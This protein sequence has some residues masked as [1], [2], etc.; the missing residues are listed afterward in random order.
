MKKYIFLFYTLLGTSLLFS[1]SEDFLDLSDPNAV[2]AGDFLG[3]STDVEVAVNGI[4]AAIRS[5]NALGESSGLY[6]DER[7]DDMGRNDNQSNAGEPFQFTD[8]SLLPSNT[9]LLNHWSALYTIVSRANYVINN[10]ETVSYADE[11]LRSSHLAQATYLRALAY[12]HLVRKWGA[13]PLVTMEIKTPGELHEVTFRESEEAVYAQIV[14]DLNVAVA[15][16]LPDHQAVSG[17]GRVSKVAAYALL[18]EV[19]LTM[20][21]NQIAGQAPA[22]YFALAKQNLDAAYSRRKF[23]DL[24]EIS[25]TSVF[26]VD[27]KSTNPELIFQIVYRQGDQNLSS[28]VAR[29]NQALGETINS[30]RPATGSGTRV[31]LDLVN[32]YEENDPRKE[33]SV[34]FASDS[35]VQEY[36]VT[37]FRDRSDAAGV[38][39]FGGNDHILLRYADVI[40]LLA[41]VN[42][43][44][45]NT[46]EA[47]AMLDQVRERAGLPV[48]AQAVQNPDYAA[49]FPTLRL[50][51]LHERRVELAF[52]QKRWFDLIRT[53]TVPE[54][55]EFF[56]NKDQAGY[57]IANLQNFSEKDRLYPIPFDEYKLDPERMYQN[58]GYN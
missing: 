44:L 1:C 11:N 47:I 42:E 50:A 52:E 20:G 10:I 7:S 54:M 19:Y 38:N 5:N 21:T 8:F 4:Y 3:T 32:E 40:L 37:K 27:Q 22:Q 23:G 36:F 30:L 53:L 16:T 48:Y 6:V 12:F 43:R 13:V 9:Y 31:N 35:R 41:E 58:P 2:P 29:N 18:G 49:K 45:G 56:G 39:G 17:K 15:S 51:I 33:F 28:A 34:K 55:V 14:N 57:G 25:Y 24:K 46:A 26:D